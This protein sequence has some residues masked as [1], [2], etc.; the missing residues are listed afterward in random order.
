MGLADDGLARR[1]PQF[2]DQLYER[3]IAEAAQRLRGQYGELD[4]LEAG[5]R[6]RGKAVAVEQLPSGPH[7][8]VVK[9]DRFALV[10]A[11]G[12]LAKQ[13]GKTVEVAMGPARAVN[14]LQ[15]AGLQLAVQ[16][17]ALHMTRS[18]GLGR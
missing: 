7:V 8:V 9:A 16:F 4:R 1:R 5:S 6:V 17:R 13:L 2:L 15:P 3:E 18:R 12:S 14:A 11:Q 10:P